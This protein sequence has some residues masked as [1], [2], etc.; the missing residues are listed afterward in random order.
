MRC[1]ERSLNSSVSVHE[2]MATKGCVRIRHRTSM[3]P[4]DAVI[5]FQCSVPDFVEVREA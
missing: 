1:E 2:T 5:I 4:R 3:K